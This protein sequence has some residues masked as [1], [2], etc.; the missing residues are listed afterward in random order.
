VF[1]AA[2]FCLWIFATLLALVVKEGS[3]PNGNLDPFEIVVIAM[4]ACSNSYQGSI[5][6]G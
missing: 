6:A 2:L 1:W 5:H 3:K 4:Y